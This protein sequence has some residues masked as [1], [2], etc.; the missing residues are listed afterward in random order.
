[1]EQVNTINKNK[2]HISVDV[3]EHSCKPDHNHIEP[4]TTVYTRMSTDI[5]QLSNI[6]I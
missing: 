1:M 2:K 4:N 3:S 6:Y 5:S